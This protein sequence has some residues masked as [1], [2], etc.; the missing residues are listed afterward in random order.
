[1]TIEV[2]YNGVKTTFQV[3]E[4]ALPC[5]ITKGLLVLEVLEDLRFRV[6]ELCS[7]RLLYEGKLEYVTPKEYAA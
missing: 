2:L 7:T 4:G 3:P 5:T 6:F 1:M